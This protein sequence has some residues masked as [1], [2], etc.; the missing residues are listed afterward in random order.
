VVLQVSLRNTRWLSALGLALSAVALAACSSSE[1]SAGSAT[2][3]MP[4]ISGTAAVGGTEASAGGGGSGA[5]TSG[6]GSDSVGGQGGSAGSEAQPHRVTVYTT[7]AAGQKLAQTELGELAA[8]PTGTAP[9]IGVNTGAPR[10][11]IV[12][13]G[14]S[15]TESTAAVLAK[16]PAEKRTAVLNAYFSASGADYT[17]TRTHIGS[18]DFS[19]GKYSYAE[20]ES[21]TLSDFTIAPDEDDLL[22][23]IQ[24]SQ[25]LSPEGFKIIASPWSSPPWMKTIGDWYQPPSAANGYKGTGG[26]LKDEHRAT[27]ALYLSK[28]VSAYEA[29]GVPI[30]AI[31]PENEPLGNSGQWESLEFTASEMN[32]FIRDFLG[33]L[34][35]K[36]HPQTQI[37][38]FD[39]NRPEAP[40]W[41]NAIL[42]DPVT[43]PFVSGT[44]VHW[45]ASTFQVYPDLLDQIHDAY[46]D[47]ILLNS[48]ATIDA[49]RDE[50][51]E[52]NPPGDTSVPW[53]KATGELL[54]WKNDAWWWQKNASDWG[55]F[56]ADGQAG[57]SPADQVDHP[58]YEPVYRYARD[59]IEGM[60][61]WFVGWVDWNL[62]LDK[63][64]GPN[65]VGNWAAAPIMVDTDN[66]DVYFTPLYYVMSHFSKFSRPG[67]H[68]VPTSVPTELPLNATATVDDDG[69]VTLHVLNTSAQP[70]RYT[71]QLP[72]GAATVEIGAATLQTVVVD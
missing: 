36:D 37:L 65:H 21:T 53:G 72:S 48:E 64:G 51:R 29:K 41:A 55:Y 32:V 14:G 34:F 60:N 66:G 25:A 39:Q 8:A 33:P 27:F 30:W 38:A 49:L 62:V 42:G 3:G 31:T 5:G 1:P 57:T 26:K 54:Y 19:F 50:A 11:A 16:L 2:A 6:G 9:V 7:S 56:W 4:G 24:D 15:F 12:G 18:S 52:M 67:A 43:S 71:L 10:Q 61:H 22:P 69:Q 59:I 40:A 17:L 70:Y 23:L 45:Y 13:F 20:T 47:K 68:V 63:L 35:A 58:L 44:A 28:Y 46:P